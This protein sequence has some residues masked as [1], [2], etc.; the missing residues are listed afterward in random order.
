[1]EKEPAFSNFPSYLFI[2]LFIYVCI[3]QKQ[4]F[5]GPLK[6]GKKLRESLHMLY[7]VRKFPAAIIVGCQFYLIVNQHTARETAEIE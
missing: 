4:S 6:V 3:I 7:G 5:L 2:Y 1:M